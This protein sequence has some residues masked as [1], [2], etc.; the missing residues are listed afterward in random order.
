MPDHVLYSGNGIVVTLGLIMVGSRTYPVHSVLSL[1]TSKDDK[2]KIL[3]GCMVIIVMVVVWFV[4]I[5]IAGV[6]LGISGRTGPQPLAV[7]SI[8]VTCVVLGAIL[9]KNILVIRDTH[10]ASG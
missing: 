7:I 1:S 4:L 10:P 3:K 2:P 5:L 6:G 8:T 9:A